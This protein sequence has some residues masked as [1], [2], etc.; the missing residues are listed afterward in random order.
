MNPTDGRPER[1]DNVA[2][3]VSG[4]TMSPVF[5]PRLRLAVGLGDPERA[6]RLL[7]GLCAA[8]DVA[9]VEHCLTADRLLWCVRAGRA[10]AALVAADLHRLGGE[11][12]E[13]LARAEAAV[14]VLT[15]DPGAPRWRDFPAPVLPVGAG[16]HLVREALTSA[17][18]GADLPRS[19]GA[20]AGDTG[21]AGLA[22]AQREGAP[23]R[24]AG[25]GAAGAASTRP[26]TASAAK[27]SPE[28]PH[29]HAAGQV[30]AAAGTVPDP[31]P[32]GTMLPSRKP[33]AVNEDR[34]VAPRAAPA[35][36]A[37]VLAVCSGHGSPGNT[38]I[39][40]NLAV[41]LGAAV[42][43]ILVDAALIAPGV[44]AALRLSRTRSL[45]MLAHDAPRTPEEWD[46]SLTQETQPLT[47]RSPYGKAL[48]GV[49]KPALRAAVS[50]RF[51]AELVA[52]LRE[53]FRYV[54]LDLGDVADLEAV[55][56]LVAGAQRA[57]LSGA[58]YVCLV[59]RPDPVGVW[60]AQ[61]ARDVLWG[62][63][64]VAPEQTS[65]VLNHYDAR[66][67]HRRGEIEWALG[68]PAAALVP[69]DHGRIQQ[70][71]GELRPVVLD[72]RS[73]S[74]RALLDFAER[75]FGGRLTLPSEPLSGDARRATGGLDRPIRYWPVAWAVWGRRL[76][77]RMRSLVAAGGAP[78][79]GAAT[80]P[81][82]GP[83]ATEADGTESDCVP[84]AGAG[85]MPGRSEYSGVALPGAGADGPAVMRLEG[86]AD[87][88]TV[89]PLA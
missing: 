49:P 69:H 40:V 24:A 33:V 5:R 13:A 87:D 86:V 42:P 89:A 72:Q 37:I 26:A 62:H 12:L 3:D 67:H 29:A 81:A 88:R 50:G 9:V 47:A 56:P 2:G 21:G 68:V 6:A 80:R 61:E 85:L 52:R 1:R 10:D 35:D 16:Q 57:A 31:T 53:R 59:A 60:R 65:L 74:G 64:A 27:Q 20:Q 28:P 45:V 51:V 84:E 58:D 30:G 54:V 22:G 43:T 39:A 63:A 8:G 14:V 55:D 71:L 23:G 46:R 66:R 73:A 4:G 48:C 75:A 76:L 19:V 11:R 79:V 25:R 17:L 41:A 32:D 70:A 7:P 15:P 82:A 77:V 18:R 83:P 78:G 38:T 44:A 36:P 34:A